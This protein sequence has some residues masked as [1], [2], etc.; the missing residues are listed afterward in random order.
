MY[1]HANDPG[2]VKRAYNAL[3]TKVLISNVNI[4]STSTRA[5]TSIAYLVYTDTQKNMIATKFQ[6]VSNRIQNIIT[7]SQNT[8]DSCTDYENA[9]LKLYK[10]PIKSVQINW[11]SSLSLDVR[12]FIP[13][14]LNC[15]KSV[16]NYCMFKDFRV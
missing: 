5:V 12:K 13:R 8:T 11:M 2:S 9:Q 10:M 16:T 3:I 4:L 14:K 6:I 1:C 7:M 15:L